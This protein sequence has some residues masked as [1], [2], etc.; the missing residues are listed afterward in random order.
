MK[1]ECDANASPTRH[2]QPQL[3][4][5]IDRALNRLLRARVTPQSYAEF[6]RGEFSSLTVRL[7]DGEVVPL[8]LLTNAR[9]E[10]IH[11]AAGVP[12]PTQILSEIRLA[13]RARRK[14]SIAPRVA[15]PNGRP[16]AA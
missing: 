1:C 11:A 15:S 7:K 9:N 2:P 12:L 5:M 4:T 10:S 8:F 14:S 6:A 3:H 13:S 16:S